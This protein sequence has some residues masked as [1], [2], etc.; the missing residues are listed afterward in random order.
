MQTTYHS[1]YIYYCIQYIFVLDCVYPVGIGVVVMEYITT[2]TGIDFSP[3][4]PETN[5]IELEDIA[6]ALSMTC[7][8]N[9]HFLQFYSVAQHCI[10]CALEAKVR[11]FSQKVQLACLLH[12][13]SEAYISDITRSVKKHLSGYMEIE[14]EIQDMIY[15]KYLDS[16]LSNDEHALVAQVDNDMVVSEFDALMGKKVFERLSSILSTPSFESMDSLAVKNIYMRL[17]DSLISGAKP[18]VALG[19]DGCRY[20][21]CVVTLDSLGNSSMSLIEEGKLYE[22]VKIDADIAFLDMPIG[23]S[24]AKEERAFDFEARK[25]LGDRR[26]SIFPTPCKKAVYNKGTYEE[27]SEIN[28]DVQGRK[29]SRQ[30]WA[31]IPKIREVDIL[32]RQNPNMN[33]REGHPELSFLDLLGYPCKHHKRDIQG[34]K[35]RVIAL[36]NHMDIFALLNS[37]EYTSKEVSRDDI[38]DAAVLALSGLN[39]LKKDNATIHCT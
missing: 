32:L 9:G 20:G 38:I 36:R 26:S 37:H 6:H 31:L 30:S 16:P 17:V 39:S 34:E 25:V 22:L 15:R 29:L 27:D 8:A 10:N 18:N 33:L 13:G 4:T 2:Y 12:D 23:L 11:G 19:I 21:W 5:G 14:S 1:T 3:L 24:N 7:R 28:L 35:E